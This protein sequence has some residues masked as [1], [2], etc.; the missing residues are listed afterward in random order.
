MSKIIPAPPTSPLRCEDLFHPQALHVAWRKVRG[1]GGGPG[2]DGVTLAM[3]GRDID[4]TLGRLAVALASGSYRPG[5]LR[6][7]SIPKPSGGSRELAVP[8][9]V[10]RVAQTAVLLALVPRLD[11]RLAEESFAYRPGRSVAQALALARQRIAEG[12]VW[13]VDADIERFFDS[14]PHRP[15]LLDLTIW[16]DDPRLLGLIGLWLRAFAPSGRGLPQGAPL[17]PLLANLYL[18]PLDRLLVAANIAAVRYADDFVLLC[19]SRDAAERAC[20]IAAATLRD[21]GLRL[22]PDKTRIVPAAQGIPFLGETLCPPRRLP[23]L[24]FLLS[25]KSQVR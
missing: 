5:P 23:A 22:H 15:L 6:R 20:A 13:V 7:F 25:R 10:D 19:Q 16:L 21:R 14:V 11:G 3:F 9:V 18:H 17:S 12:L 8:C 2:G 24:S 1:N 4:R